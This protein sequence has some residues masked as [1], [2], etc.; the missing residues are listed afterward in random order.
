MYMGSVQYFP[1]MDNDKQSRMNN[2]E[3]SQVIHT[4][5]CM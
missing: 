1:V 4:Y 5:I 2:G 3:R